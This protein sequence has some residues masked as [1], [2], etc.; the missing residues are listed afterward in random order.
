MKVRNLIAK[1][2]KTNS[3]FHKHRLKNI[4]IYILKILRIDYKVKEKEKKP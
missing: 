4:Y 2:T 3:I 1:N